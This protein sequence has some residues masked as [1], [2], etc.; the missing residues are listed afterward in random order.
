[1]ARVANPFQAQT[2][3][4][5]AIAGLG[6]AIFGGMQS[7]G[8]LRKQ[9]LENQ[10][11]R[12]RT[13]SLQTNTRE[14]QAAIDSRSRIASIFGGLQA[15]PGQAVAPAGPGAPTGA[16]QF[17]GDMVARLAAAGG[18][19]TGN[20][21]D[22]AN[23]F[24]FAT[25]NT[26]SATD[27][28][29]ARA[30]AGAGQRLGVDQAVSLSGQAAVAQRNQQ[31]QLAQ[32]AAKVA[33]TQESLSQVRGRAAQA[34][35]DAEQ[36]G[37]TPVTTDQRLIGMGAQGFGSPL[38][39]VADPTSP[40]GIFLTPRS[41]AAGMPGVAPA[42]RNRADI[43]ITTSVRAQLQKG[44][45]SFGDFNIVMDVVEETAKK[46]PTIFGLIGNVR[47]GIQ[48]VGG[49]MDAIS[50]MF[51]GA[52][53]EAAAAELSAAGVDARHFDPNLPIID[54]MATLAAYQAAGALADQTGR[55]LSDQDFNKFRGIVGDPKEW[56]ETQNNFLAGTRALR[57]LANRMMRNRQAILRGDIQPGNLQIDGA[58]QQDDQQDDQQ[59][60]VGTRENP[61]TP[62]TQAEIDAAPPGTVFD[63]DGQLM[64]K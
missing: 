15:P 3:I 45:I 21:Q 44:E 33:A 46:D 26:P 11:L 22:L 4:G 37:G 40:S 50:T 34:T 29:V 1:M 56:T 55:G 42:S 64:V 54:K 9:Q 57:Q 2:P 60:E 41:E 31:N 48:A 20:P 13:T 10:L 16:S 36:P 24:R 51:G 27:N 43:G 63:I 59:A 14:T 49:Q 47:R 18:G 38:E 12:A 30:L 28:Q 32:D 8:E 23:L 62:K 17:S 7:P 25:A 39:R 53:F 58:D 5:A 19:L 6:D 52:S 61:I 35:I